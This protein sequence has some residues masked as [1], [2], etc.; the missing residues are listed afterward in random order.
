MKTVVKLDGIDGTQPGGGP[1]AV[2]G[3]GALAW[4]DVDVSNRR[5][6]AATRSQPRAHQPAPRRSRPFGGRARGG[7]RSYEVLKRLHAMPR[8]TVPLATVVLV[9]VGLFA[10]PVVGG[11]CL[12]AVAAFLGWLAYLAWPQLSRGGRVARALV[13]G[14]VTG[15]AVARLLDVWG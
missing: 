4:D 12:L 7:R 6:S 3:R 2:V 1:S 9:F 5:R 13:L 8:W 10:G 11:L 14:M 15:V